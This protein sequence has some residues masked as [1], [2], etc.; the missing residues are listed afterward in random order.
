[1]SKINRGFTPPGFRNFKPVSKQ[2]KKIG[3]GSDT[4]Q[5]PLKPV[6]PVK[7]VKSV[8]VAKPVKQVKSVPLPANKRIKGKS[9]LCA[10]RCDEHVLNDLQL[11]ADDMERP[12][13]Y[14]IRKSIESYLSSQ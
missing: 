9:V 6:K 11:L 12:L 8:P 1:M 10:F 5:K 13:S 3:F 4:V 7:Q 14:L 2:G